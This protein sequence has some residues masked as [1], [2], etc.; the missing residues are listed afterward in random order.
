MVNEIETVVLEKLYRH[1]YIGGRHTAVESL[2]KGLPKHL[3]GEVK[4]TVKK[5]ARE[6]WITQKPTSY[7]LQI[8]LNPR[9]I[10]EVE[11]ILGIEG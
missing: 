8:S 10:P 3:R 1:G 2:V 11:R 5:L 7:G 6:G 9:V 4:K